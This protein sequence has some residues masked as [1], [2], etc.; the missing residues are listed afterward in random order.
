MT[1]ILE[2]VIQH[3][4]TLFVITFVKDVQ[5][6]VDRQGLSTNSYLYLLQYNLAQI[7]PNLAHMPFKT[8]PPTNRPEGQMNGQ[9]GRIR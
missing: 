2:G 4:H 9:T 6:K 7:D 5:N 8:Y 3:L 1:E